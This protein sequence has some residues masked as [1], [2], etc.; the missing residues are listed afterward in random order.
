MLGGREKQR[1]VPLGKSD[2]RCGIV[3]VYVHSLL[4]DRN[5][6]F[7]ALKFMCNLRLVRLP[8]VPRSAGFGKRVPK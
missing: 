3:S 5:S 4:E 7:V 1:H 2:S 8:R 6:G